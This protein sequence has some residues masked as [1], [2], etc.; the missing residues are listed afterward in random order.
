MERQQAVK[1]VLSLPVR[2]R[3]DINATGKGVGIA[4]IDSDFAR[5]PDLTKPANRIVRYVDAV[6]GAEADLPP[7]KTTKARQWHG[8]MTAVTAAGNGYLSQGVY[9]SLAPDATVTL[10]RTMNDRGRVTT[11]TIVEA[12]EYVRLHA[13]ELGIRVVNI[14]VYADEVDQTLDHPVNEAVEKLVQDGICVI[15]AAGNNPNVPIR[16]PA[17]APS[18]IAVGGLNDNNSLRTD[19]D[20]MYPSTFGKTSMGVQKP[21]VIAPAI[22]L[23]AP[24]LLGT[25]QRKEASALCAMDAM[26][27]AM[28]LD[29]AP[30][31][32]PHTNLPVSVWTS[33]STPELRA[34]IRKRIADEQICGPYYKMVDGTSFS[35][36]I[37]ASIVAQMLEIDPDLT[38][39]DVKAILIA[40]ARPLPNVD[41]LAQGAG[42]V[43]QTDTLAAVR[44]AVAQPT[45]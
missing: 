26:D 10:I 42:V 21:D 39:A 33:R 2:L 32:M 8:T 3:A 4:M 6:Q 9:T 5:H 13:A 23:P 1:P 12:L 20:T 14:S 16:P 17:A 44:D 27:D 37:V 28:L 30:S 38:P 25:S 29:C 7:A 41:P 31:L 18:G 35:A 22:Y 24:I 11:D 15:S 43:H 45:P 34:A 19:D 36:P 40:N